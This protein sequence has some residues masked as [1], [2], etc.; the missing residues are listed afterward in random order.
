[1]SYY[2]MIWHFLLLFST[3]STS[4]LKKSKCVQIQ[5]FGVFAYPCPGISQIFGLIGSLLYTH[6][7]SS[8]ELSFNK[9]FFDV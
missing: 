1:M 4:F 5:L 7:K 3:S 2:I 8:L 9:V 6:T